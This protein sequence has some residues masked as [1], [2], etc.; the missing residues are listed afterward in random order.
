MGFSVT[1]SA[2]SA[3]P[4]SLADAKAH[5]AVDVDDDDANIGLMITAAR[6][7]FESA[8]NRLLAA[9]A[10]VLTLDDFPR[11]ASD[12]TDGIPA[13][14][15]PLWP[16]ASVEAVN[17]IDS[18]GDEQTIDEDDWTTF[19]DRKPSL[20]YPAPG[21]VWPTVQYGRLGAVSVE[22]TAGADPEL[23]QGKAAMLLMIAYWY[24]PSGRGDGEDPTGTDPLTRGI[25]AGAQAIMNGLMRPMYT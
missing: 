19:L 12:Y 22:F 25:P 3:E 18:A 21:S 10:C 7:R 5:L 20:V 24:G 2:V 17:Y 6:K 8:T 16:V 13:I 9:R 1:Q 4:L 14:R 11:L 15:V 23:A